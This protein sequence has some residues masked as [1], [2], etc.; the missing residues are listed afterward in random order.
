MPLMRRLMELVWGIL[1]I[2]WNRIIQSAPKFLNFLPSLGIIILNMWQKNHIIWRSEEEDMRVGS[3]AEI[4]SLHLKNIIKNRTL[5]EFWIRKY[6]QIQLSKRARVSLLLILHCTA[7]Q[8]EFPHFQVPEAPWGPNNPLRVKE[9]SQKFSIWDLANCKQPG[10]PA[11][12]RMNHTHVEFINQ[13]IDHF[14]STMLKLRYQNEKPA[15]LRGT[16]FSY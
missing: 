11:N 12:P 5:H 15:L 1:N 14:T 4:A 3:D 6:P 13:F 7:Q 16:K 9:S 2:C 8:L 10:L